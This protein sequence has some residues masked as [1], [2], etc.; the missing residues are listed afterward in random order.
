MIVYISH[1]YII[2]P[3]AA[4]FLVGSRVGAGLCLSNQRTVLLYLAVPFRMAGSGFPPSFPLPADVRNCRVLKTD[5]SEKRPVAG[6]CERGLH[7]QRRAEL[8]YWLFSQ[9]QR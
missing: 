2:V 6:T 8:G 9:V 1:T 7:A 4:R 5:T 3:S